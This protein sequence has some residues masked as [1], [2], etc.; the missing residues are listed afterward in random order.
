MMDD[1]HAFDL[2]TG[3]PY[4]ARIDQVIAVSKSSRTNHEVEAYVVKWDDGDT[5]SRVA[6]HDVTP[7]GNPNFLKATIRPPCLAT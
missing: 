6:A 5:P 3:T 2:N 4:P 7:I 1:I